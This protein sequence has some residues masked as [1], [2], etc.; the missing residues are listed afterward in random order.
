MRVLSENQPRPD[1]GAEEASGRGALGGTTMGGPLAV[2]KLA[3]RSPRERRPPAHGSVQ[4]KQKVLTDPV[5]P[6]QYIGI[7][8]ESHKSKARNDHRA[9]TKRPSVAASRD[10][11]GV[12]ARTW[13]A[14]R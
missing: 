1:P 8:N 10:S 3:K 5:S 4:L 11:K 12:P 6:R 7:K 2:E 13:E 14:S 9:R